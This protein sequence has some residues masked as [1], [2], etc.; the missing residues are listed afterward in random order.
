MKPRIDKKKF[1]WI[2]IQDVKFNYDVIIRLNGTIEKRKK[3]LSKEIYGTSHIISIAEAKFV[4]EDGAKYLIIGAG[5][6]GLVKLSNDAADYFKK[7]G[8]QVEVFPTPQAIDA[9]N[10]VEDAAIGLFHVTC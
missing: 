7:M 8:C 2:I 6:Q 10:K 1:G 4:Y 5:Q 3:I 9:W